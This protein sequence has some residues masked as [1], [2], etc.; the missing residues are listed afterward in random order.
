MET[1]REVMGMLQDTPWGNLLA[2]AAAI[3]AVYLGQLL[4]EELRR[5][6]RRDES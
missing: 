4:G 6:L 3:P 1:A 5:V 2:L